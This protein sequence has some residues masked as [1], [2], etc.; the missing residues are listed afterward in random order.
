MIIKY[1]W[2]V[3]AA[4][5][6]NITN[7]HFIPRLYHTQRGGCNMKNNYRCK[8]CE[9]YLDPGEGRLCKDCL[10]ELEKAESLRLNS[11]N[12]FELCGNSGKVVTLMPLPES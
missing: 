12:G 5:D 2:Q 10:E 7:I 4:K 6:I 1:P 8:K 11:C 9:C 3:E